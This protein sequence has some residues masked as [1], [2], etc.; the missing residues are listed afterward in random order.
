MLRCLM[1]QNKGHTSVTLSLEKSHPVTTLVPEPFK[2]KILF[3]GQKV[4]FYIFNLSLAR[5]TPCPQFNGI[6]CPKF[7]P[8]SQVH[9]PCRCFALYYFCHEEECSLTECAFPGKFGDLE[10]WDQ[11]RKYTIVSFHS[12]ITHTLTQF[13]RHK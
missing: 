1:Y 6:A 4:V 5:K 8:N 7:Y 11:E 10:T 12:H 2:K 3:Y 9:L 13:S